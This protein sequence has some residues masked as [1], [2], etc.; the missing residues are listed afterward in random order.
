LIRRW[1][2]YIL[3]RLENKP[4]VRELAREYPLPDEDKLIQQL[5]AIRRPH[6]RQG[7][8]GK[9]LRESHPKHHGCVRAEFIVE[10]G[11]PEDLRVG[12]FAKERAYPAWIRFSNA[13]G[14]KRDG[15][16]RKDIKLDLRGAAI[17]VMAVEGEKIL[18]EEKH[19]TTQ[20]FLLISTDA[21]FVRDLAAFV[22]LLGEPRV[23]TL[24][25]Y[26]FNPLDLHLRELR[27][28]LRSVKR[29]A[30]PLDIEYSS[31]VPFL[32]G[33]RAVKYKLRPVVDKP[34][35]APKCP[36]ADFLRDAMQQRLAGAEARFDLMLQVQT[37][38]YKMPVEDPSVV[39]DEGLSP[40]RKV[41]TVRI[42][43]QRF[44]SAAQM[45]FCEN[46][47]FNPWHSLPEHRPLGGLNRA[48]KVVYL[49]LAKLR[50]ELNQA[51]VKE[52]S[53]GHSF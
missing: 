47:S 10:P 51:P 52:P 25:W 1:E 53:P 45:E 26:F 2:G 41:A 40:F 29:I 39:W 46:L 44:D 20:D 21:L 9:F 4:A 8:S 12:V 43:E 22:K 19:E 7:P 37:D 18:E 42:P 50:H 27:I 17:K 16:Y 6:V 34:D 30:N 49:A 11:L 28:G 5:L 38:P 48:R 36:S 15:S 24:L 13:N 14:L 31:V 23:L 33:D 3:V 35:K 32:F